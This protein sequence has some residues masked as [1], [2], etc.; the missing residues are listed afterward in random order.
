[1]DTRTTDHFIR[2]TRAVMLLGSECVITGIN[3]QIAQTIVHMGVN[4]EGIT[5]FRTLRDAL[6][7][8][9]TR[10]SAAQQPARRR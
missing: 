9:V 1:M 10:R 3:P 8:F 4:L 2:M 6:R 5:T 7:S